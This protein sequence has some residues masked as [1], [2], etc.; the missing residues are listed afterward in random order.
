LASFR[1]FV[2]FPNSV[3]RADSFAITVWSW[4]CWKIGTSGHLWDI[5]HVPLRNFD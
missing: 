3:P 5:S 4:L 1:V 2:T